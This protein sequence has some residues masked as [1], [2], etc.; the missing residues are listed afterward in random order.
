[1]W[2][3]H[4]CGKPVYF[5]ERKQS[6]GYDWH[7]ECLR[8]DE[9]GKRLNPG[10]H[11]EHKG[12][13]YCHV[14]CYG[15]L[16][17]PQLFGHG[18]RVESHKSYGVKGAQKP[19]AQGNG[20]SLP[21]DHLESK[22]KVYNQFYDNK[23]LEIRSREVNN[24]L[25]LEGALRVYWGVQGVIHL[26][27]DDDQRTFVVR[28][29]NSCRSSKAAD[30]ST[31]DKENEGSESLA[32]PT[33]T[34]S[35]VEGLSTDISLSESMTFDSCSLNEVSE[36]PTT[37]EDA[38]AN[39]ATGGGAGSHVN[40]CVNNDEDDQE[41]T[42]TDSSNTLIGSDVSANTNSTNCVSCTLPSK[43][44][45]L[46]KLDW[47]EID[48]LLQVE[49]QHNDKDK[50]YETMPVKL[51]SSSSTSSSDSSP[52]KTNSAQNSTDSTN[53]NDTSMPTSTATQNNNNSNTSS[54]TT[55]STPTETS[56]DDFMTATASLTTNTNTQNTTTITTTTTSL[57][58]YETSDDATL[59]AMDFEDFKRSV[60]Q[61]YVNGANS[62]Q[63][64]NDDTLKRNQPIDP[65]R[66]HDS[67]KLYG[68]NSA[69]SKSFNCEHALRS[70]DPNF[71]NDTMNL[72]S[73]VDSARSSQRQYALQK[74]G[75]ASH[76][77][78]RDNNNQQH[79]INPS[80]QRGRQ[81]F[82]KGINRSKSGPSCFV[83]SDSDDDES[84]LRPQ[85]MAT[86]RR[87]DVPQRFIQIQMNC[88]AKEGASEGESSRNEA[89][90]ITNSGAVAGDEL[91]QT[92]ELFTASAGTPANDVANSEQPLHVT[93]DGV[94]LRRPPRTGAAAIKRRSGNRRSRTKLKRRCS[95]NGHFY[96]RETSFFTPPHGSQMS[97]WVTSLVTTQEVIN[98][99]LEK[100]KVDS[101][102]ENFSLF[103]IRDNGEQKRLKDNEYPLITRV[104]LGPH[105]DV[106]RLF[107]MDSRKT[108]EIS[109]EVAQFLNLSL[110]ECRSILDRY[111]QEMA[112][113]VAKIKERYAEL[114]RRI[115]SRMESLKVHL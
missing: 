22:L 28:K 26:K 43:L 83:Y 99:V 63:E 13:P 104:T 38:S 62:F 18:T 55:N 65:S 17:G 106:A 61:D 54:T 87:S 48:D 53:P 31:S 115:V 12:V 60:H 72:R 41:T 1:M 86:I 39:T 103:I 64:H 45:K 73:S 7:P 102:P 114:R 71:I 90:S 59:K 25:I 15:A 29:R 35:E 89:P 44:D 23:S 92:E 79:K 46:E 11:A 105:E 40:G 6:L 109:N 66:I 68:E 9:C 51:P 95:I 50:M 8:C 77:V 76:A 5:A 101:A 36:L 24:R 4:K 98:L 111:D 69:M 14:P 93:E 37:P 70:I 100:Y 88:Y 58:N 52:T 97:V 107:L 67:L 10:Q 21:R 34:A 47:D 113:E 94:V 49:R 56:S 3:C 32:A 27:E 78:S 96:N 80:I 75:S 91:T 108:D 112:R 2:K 85:R 42:T 16:F 19:V 57:D 82:E 84:T 33:T 74:S 30:D 81:V 110:P 20:P